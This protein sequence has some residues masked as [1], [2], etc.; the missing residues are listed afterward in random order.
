M[1]LVEIY[2]VC[3]YYK[4]IRDELNMK[5]HQFTL[6]N[7]LAILNLVNKFSKTESLKN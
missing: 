2:L 4:H 1:T 6:L 5:V 3:K 7:K